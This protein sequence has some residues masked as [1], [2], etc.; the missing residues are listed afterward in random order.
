M[1]TDA[2]DRSTWPRNDEV[3]R[4]A[5]LLRLI[6]D[7][8]GPRGLDLRGA[9]FVGDGP[10]DDPWDNPIDLTPH[11]LAPVAQAHREANDG[12]DP[13]WLGRAGGIDLWCACLQQAD[14]RRA[15]LWGGLTSGRPGSRRPI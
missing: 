6:E 14:L 3:I 12:S 1:T 8:G 7:N 15:Q 9:V 4:R 10:S 5:D 2:E 11:S 13:P